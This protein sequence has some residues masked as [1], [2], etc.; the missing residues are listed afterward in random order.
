MPTAK[1]LSGGVAA[2]APD[3]TALNSWDLLVHGCH[4]LAMKQCQQVFVARVTAG[5]R[6]S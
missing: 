5:Y 2:A 1:T 4:A 3:S 6:A